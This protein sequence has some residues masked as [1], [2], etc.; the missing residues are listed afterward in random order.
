MTA[1]GISVAREDKKNGHRH[2]RLPLSVSVLSAICGV[3][4]TIGAAAAASEVRWRLKSSPHFEIYHEPSWP[5]QSVELELERLY[6]KLRFSV[7]MFAPW[8]AREKT[9]I[10]IYGSRESYLGGEFK[11]PKWSKG[12][13]FSSGK[14]VVVYDTGDMAKLRA[15][16][17]HELSHL[18]FESFYGERLKYP[19][20]WLNEGLAVMLENLSY[21]GEGPWSQALKYGDT[22]NFLPPES[23]FR[24]DPASLDSDTRISYWYLQAFG[25]VSYLYRPG[26]RLQFM[27]FCSLL[28][29]GKTLDSALWEAYRISGLAGLEA[30]WRKWVTAYRNGNSKGSSADFASTGYDFKP[31][32]FHR[33]TLTGPAGPR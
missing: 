22:G 14:T 24:S 30:D 21:D 8:M 17:V 5:P 31:A 18:Y 15:V 3:V 32:E 9:R 23:F 25:M 27:N 20:A 28:R 10:Y 29:K 7:S 33:F 26:K 6:G 1:C 11:P 12:L 4:L 2:S 16:I 13:A 19:P